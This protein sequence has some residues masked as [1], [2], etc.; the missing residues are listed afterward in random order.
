[1][2]LS[3]FVPLTLTLTLALT[4]TLT[5]TLANALSLTLTDTFLA[6]SSE[7][8]EGARHSVIVTSALLAVGVCLS[9]SL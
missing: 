1:M 7:P 3:V 8:V 5:P 9:L 6:S 2:R 4:L